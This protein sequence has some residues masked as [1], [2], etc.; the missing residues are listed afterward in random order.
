MN[1]NKAVE[2]IKPE[3]VWLDL[4]KEEMQAYL[5]DKYTTVGKY[6]S[7]RGNLNDIDPTYWI[8]INSRTMLENH[9][10]DDFLFIPDVDDPND[11]WP[12][13]PVFIRI[14]K[15][16]ELDYFIGFSKHQIQDTKFEYY[17]NIHRLLPVQ[18]TLCYPVIHEKI[19]R[20]TVEEAFKKCLTV[21]YQEKDPFRQVVNKLNKAEKG[22]MM[23]L[24]LNPIGYYDDYHPVLKLIKL[25]VET[26]EGRVRVKLNTVDDVK[27]WLDVLPIPDNLKMDWEEYRPE[28]ETMVINYLQFHQAHTHEN[29]KRTNI[30]RR[31]KYQTQ[32]NQPYPIKMIALLKYRLRLMPSY[33]T[34]TCLQLKRP[35]LLDEW[36][37]GKDRWS[38]TISIAMDIPEQL[39]TVY[40]N[41]I[42]DT[43]KGT[44]D[45]PISEIAEVLEPVPDELP[46]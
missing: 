24:A 5:K 8:Q 11:P 38:L 37:M 43:I 36:N 28:I 42:D 30:S 16:N 23:S 12:R 41:V 1:E 22:I 13:A 45:L 46:F 18:D 26:K 29:T 21:E 40:E 17:I 7:I 3:L 9:T 19:L 10:I 27:T 4:N 6:V 31:Y 14:A 32:Y 44:I 20:E 25:L 2:E 39:K 33:F 34:A 35:E 15:I